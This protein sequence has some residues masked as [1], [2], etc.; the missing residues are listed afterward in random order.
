MDPMGPNEPRGVTKGSKWE[1]KRGIKG[2]SF[3]LNSLH[4]L[5]PPNNRPLGD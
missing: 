5:R 1:I 3:P 2:E 4:H